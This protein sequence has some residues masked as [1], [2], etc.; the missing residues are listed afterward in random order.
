MTARHLGLPLVVA[1][2]FGCAP[3]LAP[4]K[5]DSA[6]VAAAVA[7]AQVQAQAM[8]A[9]RTRAAAEAERE[10]GPLKT[11]QPSLDEELAL[12]RTLA[13]ATV[14]RLGHL[15]LDGTPEADPD[16]A[17]AALATAK[18]LPAGGKNAVTAHVA[19]VG[20][21]LARGSSRPDLPWTFGVID[22]TERVA[23]SAPGGWVFVTTGLLKKLTN[24]AQLAAV[25]AHEL[26]HVTAKDVLL[27]SRDAKYKQCVLGKEMQAMASASGNAAL[28]AQLHVTDTGGAFTKQLVDSTV[29]ALGNDQ[30]AELAADKTALELI[31]FAGYDALEF[32]S[33]L[34]L[35][36]PVPLHPR[37]EDWVAQLKSLRE[38][39]LKD[40]LHGTAKPDLKKP[41]AALA[42]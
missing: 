10:C 24:E 42:N 1:M 20:K 35:L 7:D 11:A 40:F 37:T 2:S 3:A 6:N 25:L 18:P 4:I 41:F 31:S 38:G 32:E 26:A 16:K 22:S 5:S 36:G 27:H 23:T 8:M 29:N 33:V 14:A 21:N 9:A 30:Q 13:V 12:G 17:A 19:I 34:T 39:S 28:M 15:Y